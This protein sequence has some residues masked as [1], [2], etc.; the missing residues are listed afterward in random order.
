M[1]VF[2]VA[3]EAESTL[4]PV[5]ARIPDEVFDRC[6]TEVLVIDDSSKDQTFE[7]GLRTAS[8]SRHP[9]TILHNPVN[10]G[11]GGN[12]KL[13]Y[14]YAIRNGFDFVVLLHGDGQYA[15]EY[16]PAMLAP[17]I[18]D[19]ADAVFGSRMLTRLGALKGG[20]PLYKFVG[21]RI[22]S[23][24]QNALLRT[25]LSEFHS[26]FRAYR[27]SSLRRL[28]FQYNSN[29]FH[30]DTDIIIQLVAGQHRIVEIPIPT[31]YGTEI[32]R[33]NGLRYA[34][35]VVTTTVA[36]RLHGMNVFYNRKFDVHDH[37][38]TH[39]A[40]KLGY[41]SSHT[42][43]LSAVPAGARVLDIGCGPGQFAEVLRTKCATVD[44]ADQFAPA[45]ASVFDEFFLWREGDILRAN[46]R[47]YDVVLLLDIIE[48]LND[49][50]AF[51]DEL[52]QSASSIDR[53]PEFVVTTGNVVFGI[54]RLQALLGQFNYGKRGI[55]D[56]TH[57]RLYTFKTLRRLFEQ[58]GFIVNEVKGIPA[59]F[60][61]A[62]GSGALA[63][64]LVW[65]NSALIRVS[66]G[67]F[68]Y[69][70]FLRAVPTATVD[71]LLDHSIEA[72]ATRVARSDGALS[73]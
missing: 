47:D 55:L 18:A 69:Q 45:D 36:S 72:S 51:L 53:R 37:G 61:L 58:S 40:L 5:L 31:Y 1:L 49:P 68:A 14:Q 13:G 6:D 56:L 26:G 73:R 4:R 8:D 30:F 21:N 16:I 35:D 67:F 25:T 11:Y 50:A 60:Q 12:Q 54:V 33:V 17:L 39:Y 46:L 23:W 2:V 64:V 28:P 24:I 59:P 62:L 70:I 65:L 15:P 41:E 42:M 57:T 29:A 3:Y 63:R 19:E 10:Q 22:L 32:C 52:R 7:V 66:K 48:H 43:A 9:I 71:A 38:N 27:V 44:G 34:R 20:M